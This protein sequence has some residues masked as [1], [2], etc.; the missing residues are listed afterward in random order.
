MS[1]IL[2]LIIVLGGQYWLAGTIM[3]SPNPVASV[4]INFLFVVV[5]AGFLTPYTRDSVADSIIE[6]DLRT[7]K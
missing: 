2:S 7:P 1:I 3:I 5:I 4:I 6:A